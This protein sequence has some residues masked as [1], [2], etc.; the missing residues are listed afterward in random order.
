MK[1]RQIILKP[2]YKQSAWMA[3]LLLGASLPAM[4]DVRI[5]EP[6]V[7][8]A[9]ATM[10]TTTPVVPV[11]AKETP[12]SA[13]VAPLPTSP[14][15]VQE[16]PQVKPPPEPTVDITPVPTPAVPVPVPSATVVTTPS[17]A[18][19]LEAEFAFASA[20]TQYAPAA[21]KNQGANSLLRTVQRTPAEIAER[22]EMRARM[23]LAVEKVAAEYGNPVFAEVF[24]N[25]PL[26]AR[27][28]GGRLQL[29]HN[30]EELVAQIGA[31]EKQR[32]AAALAVDAASRNR[33]SQIQG[34]IRQLE[35][36]R[37]SVALAVERA[38]Q[39]Q[40]AVIASEVAL[41]ER[42]K[43]VVAVDLDAKR[44]ELATLREEA[45]ALNQRLQ[46]ARS[47]LAAAALE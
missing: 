25:D 45:K 32:E 46:Q 31:L 33:M 39:Q 14:A 24:T 27:V 22:E 5:I 34:E 36:Q 19:P 10:P 44:Q 8:P 1:T 29:L 26:R 38:V 11:V 42:D 16:A 4:A 13:P 30:Y 28:L 9:Q 23:R 17:S 43:A 37:E 41:L 15:S 20:R 6:V 7:I 40:A 18:V 35:R 47:A 12:P 2:A 21:G 3:C